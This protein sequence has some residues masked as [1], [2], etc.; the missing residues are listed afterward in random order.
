[1]AT[2]KAESQWAVSWLRIVL[3]FGRVALQNFD[4]PSRVSGKKGYRLTD[5]RI[6]LIGSLTNGVSI[7]SDPLFAENSFRLHQSFGLSLMFRDRKS[8]VCPEE[9]GRPKHA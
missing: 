9:L 8:V 5:L 2:L 4:S 3:Q 6:R 7:F 1:L